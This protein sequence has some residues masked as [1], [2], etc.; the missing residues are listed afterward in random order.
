MADTNIYIYITP[1]KEGLN[2]ACDYTAFFVFQG[3]DVNKLD[4]I[5]IMVITYLC[6]SSV[7]GNG[8]EG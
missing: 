3:E 5:V 7:V 8:P 1:A 6:P 2:D 4:V